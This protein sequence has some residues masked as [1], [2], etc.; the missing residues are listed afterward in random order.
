MEDRAAQIRQRLTQLRDS[1]DYDKK[2]AQITT[3][4]SQ[5]APDFWNNQ[6]KAQATVGELKNLRSIAVPLKEALAAADD[7]SGLIEL[8]A[9]DTSLRGDG[10][11]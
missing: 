6:E 7:L 2:L 1:L 11:R 10:R 8:L 5:M 3:I 4:E 9:E